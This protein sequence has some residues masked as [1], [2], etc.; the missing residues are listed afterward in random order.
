LRCCATAACCRPSAVR[1]RKRGQQDPHD[2]LVRH[3]RAIPDVLDDGD[4]RTTGAFILI[5]ESTND[6]VAAGM[7]ADAR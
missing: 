6:T 2:L 7:I 3:E 5:D 4:N 1:R